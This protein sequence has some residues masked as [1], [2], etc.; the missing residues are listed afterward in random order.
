MN[1]PEDPLCETGAAGGGLW[2]SLLSQG[3]AALNSVSTSTGINSARIQE[4]MI[5]SRNAVHVA[6]VSAR[7]QMDQVI[8]PSHGSSTLRSPPPPQTLNHLPNNQQVGSCM[9]RPA[10]AAPSNSHPAHAPRAQ[11][12]RPPPPCPT[13]PTCHRSCQPPTHPPTHA[14]THSPSPTPPTQPCCAGPGRAGPGRTERTG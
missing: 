5:A 13:H 1:L 10:P 8:S 2:H 11:A 4:S 3:R 14:R 6:V 7:Q 12:P 9:I